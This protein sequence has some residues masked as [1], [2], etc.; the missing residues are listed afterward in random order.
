M[1]KNLLTYTLLAAAFLISCDMGSS[2]NNP[3]ITISDSPSLTD[4]QYEEV[5]GYAN[6][7]DQISPTDNGVSCLT[8]EGVTNYTLENY[9]YPDNGSVIISGTMSTTGSEESEINIDI[10]LTGSTITS[11]VYSYNSSTEQGSLT[12]NGAQYNLKA[13]TAC[14]IAIE[15]DLTAQELSQKDED[16]LS[17]NIQSAEEELQ[18]AKDRLENIELN[19][20]LSSEQ[21]DPIQNAIDSAAAALK[22]ANQALES[23]TTN[24]DSAKNK[25]QL[26][27][28][29][30]IS[31]Q[32]AEED[33]VETEEAMQNA[34]TAETLVQTA[35]GFYDDANQAAYTAMEQAAKA[36]TLIDDL[37]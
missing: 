28:T 22:D 10:S 6:L 11:L 31:V 3:A 29:K 1:K 34:Q 20:D 36:N 12:I 23:M 4:S 8:D 35:E 26:A 2:V 5:A 25:V 30:S 32:T 14:R 18:R 19:S 7:I 21:R 15:S 24:T 16:I 33:S 27:I 13:F 9:N 37:T 17:P